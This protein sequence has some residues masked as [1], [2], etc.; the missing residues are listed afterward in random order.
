[1]D[2]NNFTDNG[3]AIKRQ[4][5]SRHIRDGGNTLSISE[6]FVDMETGV[7]TQ[8]DPGS[9]PYVSL[10]VSKDGGRTFGAPRLK[11]I[12]KVGQYSSPR[13]YWK[14]L[15][16]AKDF[17]FRFTVTDPVKF[18]ITGGAATKGLSASSSVGN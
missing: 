10:E 12:G 17:V 8:S 15:G 16:R 4:V 13:P 3:V 7:G 9:D 18:V 11:S 5:T 2:D 1:M 6:L 14:R